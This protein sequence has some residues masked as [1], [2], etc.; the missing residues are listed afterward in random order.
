M[1]NKWAVKQKKR[2]LEWKRK[3]QKQQ[4]LEWSRENAPRD[5]DYHWTDV[6]SYVNEYYGDTYRNTLKDWD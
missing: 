1:M 4:R 2:N 3:M 6:S 5:E